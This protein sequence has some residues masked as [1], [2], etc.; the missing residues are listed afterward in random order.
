M[1]IGADIS[2]EDYIEKLELIETAL[3][4]TYQEGNQSASPPRATTVPTLR[5]RKSTYPGIGPPSVHPPKDLDIDWSDL[6][7]S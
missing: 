4:R 5:P 2:P 3:M 1:L 7:D 6:D